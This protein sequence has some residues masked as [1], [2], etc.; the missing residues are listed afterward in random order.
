MNDSSAPPGT[1]CFPRIIL[2]SVSSF[3]S[4]V[5][6]RRSSFTFITDRNHSLRG[7]ITTGVVDWG[8]VTVHDC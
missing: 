6:E 3:S 7:Q 8:T 4:S 2:G 1:L 5:F